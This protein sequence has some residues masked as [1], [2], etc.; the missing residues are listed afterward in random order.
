MSD[1]LLSRIAETLYWTGRYVERAD[2]TARIARRVRRTTC[3]RTRT[4]TRTPTA[5]ACWPSWA[6]PPPTRA[7]W[8]SATALSRAGLRSDRTRARSRAR[9]AAARAGM[10]SVRDVV[11]SEMWE[12]LNVTSLAAE[13]AAP[14][15]RPARA[16]H[17]PPVRPGAGRAVLRPGR[18][19]DEPRRRLAV[20][21][22]GPQ[23][24][25]GG[26]DRPAAAGPDERDPASAGLADR[27]ARLRG[28]RVVHPHPR[29]GQRP[30]RRGRVPHAG[31]AVPAVGAARADQR[32]GGPAGT[33]PGDRG[34][35][36][37]R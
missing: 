36:R 19:D 3:W 21:G 12:C 37:H 26:H 22:A 34:P 23:P 4:P 5:G 29:L 24:G 27:A 8:T 11:S 7:R 2:D 30:V 35:V 6:C 15:G 13:R 33:G 9:S 18:V 16:A 28:A 25:A 17:V 10:R 32:R 1:A 20:P 14:V 31:P